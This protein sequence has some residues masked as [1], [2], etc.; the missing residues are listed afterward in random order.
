MNSAVSQDYN[1]LHASAMEFAYNAE[2]TGV[3]GRSWGGLFDPVMLLAAQR[4]LYADKDMAFLLEQVEKKAPLLLMEG[5]AG[6]EHVAQVVFM[7]VRRLLLIVTGIA[8]ESEQPKFGDYPMQNVLR[9]G[10]KLEDILSE[11]ELRWSGFHRVVE[12]LNTTDRV[13]T[14]EYIDLTNVV[15]IVFSDG[16]ERID[17]GSSERYMLC[18]LS[19]TAWQAVMGKQILRN[20]WR[21][22]PLSDNDKSL[23]FDGETVILGL[24]NGRYV[25]IG[26]SEWASINPV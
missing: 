8:D 18:P 24:A 16:V 6:D 2:E 20:V 25:S 7:S 15:R 22:G 17:L 3:L 4:E 13:E 1:M 26:S 9:A 14:D 12:I 21:E 5:S 10:I 23:S 19:T 11:L